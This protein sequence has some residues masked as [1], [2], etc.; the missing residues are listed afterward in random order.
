MPS[1]ILTLSAKREK[2][3]IK[4]PVTIKALC[5]NTLYGVV[6]IS[7]NLCQLFLIKSPIVIFGFKFIQALINTSNNDLLSCTLNIFN[8]TA[9]LVFRWLSKS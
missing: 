8:N 1:V 5:T 4:N 2:H 3:K 7:S 9:N 6:K